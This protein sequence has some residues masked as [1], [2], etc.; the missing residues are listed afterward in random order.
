[1][2]VIKSVID[3]KVYIKPQGFLDFNNVSSLITP[4]DKDEFLKKR[5]LNI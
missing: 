2:G 1:M 5:I 4:K 3:L